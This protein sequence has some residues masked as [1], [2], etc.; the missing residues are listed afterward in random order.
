MNHEILVENVGDGFNQHHPSYANIHLEEAFVTSIGTQ[1]RNCHQMK[2]KKLSSISV[3][4]LRNVQ[5]HQMIKSNFESLFE[6]RT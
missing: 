6:S 2:I 5:S 1:V 4:Q 3:L